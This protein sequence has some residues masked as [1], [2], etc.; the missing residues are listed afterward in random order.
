MKY[1]KLHFNE[2]TILNTLVYLAISQALFS[3]SLVV[4][5]IQ[6]LSMLDPILMVYWAI[7]SWHIFLNIIGINLSKK[8]WGNNLFHIVGNG[9]ICAIYLLKI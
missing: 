8:Y 9:I 5:Y 4:A 1:L 2:I 7:N 6:E 3:I